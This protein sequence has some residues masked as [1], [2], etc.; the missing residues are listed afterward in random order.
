[1]MMKG[2]K[3][4]LMLQMLQRLIEDDK[5]VSA[6]LNIYSVEEFGKIVTFG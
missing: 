1:M 5:E 4:R 2:E 6:G 3:R